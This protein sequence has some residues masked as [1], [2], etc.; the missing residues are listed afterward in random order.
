[1]AREE[2]DEEEEEAQETGGGKILDFELDSVNVTV[3][4]PQRPS[5]GLGQSRVES[6]KKGMTYVEEYKVERVQEAQ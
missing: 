2:D 1:M 5:I 3:L 4:E 6:P